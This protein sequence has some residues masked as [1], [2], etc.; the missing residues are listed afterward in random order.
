M[1]VRVTT[2]DKTGRNGRFGHAADRTVSQLQP[3]TAR[4]KTRVVTGNTPKSST[5]SSSTG[6]NKGSSTK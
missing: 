5:S 1:G 2:T 3:S 6:T 4:V